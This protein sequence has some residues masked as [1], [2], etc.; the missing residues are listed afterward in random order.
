M[1]MVGTIHVP[2]RCEYSY[3]LIREGVKNLCA[4]KSEK[5]LLSI[6]AAG[7]QNFAIRQQLH[8][9]P[10][11]PLVHIPRW[12]EQACSRII[13]FGRVAPHENIESTAHEHPAIR[14]QDCSGIES[15]L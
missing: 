14:Q 5:V 1:D 2:D 15:R 4:G 3:A 6:A 13:D 11:T 12:G 9:V 10:A 7:D 8:A